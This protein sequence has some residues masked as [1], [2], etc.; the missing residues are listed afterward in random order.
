MNKAPVIIA[1]DR[2]ILPDASVNNEVFEIHYKMNPSLWDRAFDFMRQRDLSSLQKG[3]YEPEGKDLVVICDEYMSKPLSD[4]RLEAHRKY[5]DIQYLISGTE[6]MGLTVTEKCR[7]TIPYDGERDIVFLD[8][9]KEEMLT[10]S[11]DMYFIFFPE[12]AH[13][14]GVAGVVPSAVKKIVIKVRIG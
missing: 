5:A 14:P 4:T 7:V 9:D 2:E 6:M 10:A 12:D 1:K 11:P 8:A 3:R 13:R